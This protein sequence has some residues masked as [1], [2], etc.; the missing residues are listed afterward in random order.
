MFLKWL[1]SYTECHIFSSTVHIFLSLQFTEA[2][3]DTATKSSKKN[4]KVESTNLNFPPDV[5]IDDVMELT[6]RDSILDL[7]DKLKVGFLGTLK[8]KDRDA[9]RDA[10]TKGGYDKSCDKLVYGPNEA[11]ADVPSH[12]ALEKIKGE[13]RNSRPGTPDSEVGSAGGK[14]YRDPGRYLGPP[15]EN[16]PSP[17]PKQQN[18]IRQMACAILQLSNAVEPKFLKKP[19]GVDDKEKFS[20]DE[21]RERW[22]QSLMAST[23]WSQ[24]FV[25]LNTLE[26]RVAWGKSA[27]NARCRICRRRR[28]AENMLLCDGCNKGHHLHCLK[29]KLTVRTDY[30]FIR[31]EVN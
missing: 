29:P 1:K 16:E 7:E 11:E 21:S 28:N 27:T 18:S 23:S 24:L 26:N 6:L 13:S 31:Y 3:K 8:V 10:I 4:N 17:D 20:F 15:A 12:T 30:L 22:E 2:P 19:V 14:V 9:W 5:A 25:H